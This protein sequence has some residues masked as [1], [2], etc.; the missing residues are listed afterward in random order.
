[1]LS[2]TVAFQTPSIRI[3]LLRTLAGVHDTSLL[4]GAL[5]LLSSLLN[6]Q[7]EERAWLDTLADKEQNEYL[8]LVVGSLTAQS[9]SLL[10]DRDSDAGKIIRSLLGH[11]Q[12]D[13]SARLRQLVLDR[14]ASGVLDSL[15]SEDKVA[16]LGH[17]VKTLHSLDD[18][19]Q[20]SV[21]KA[22][23]K[24]FNLDVTSLILV[25][26]DLSKPLSDSVAQP[27]KQ[28]QDGR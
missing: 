15:P 16:C 23:L 8:R 2:H 18:A 13:L 10:V 24:R 11:G 25:I 19:A 20:A 9:T 26:D 21:V 14:M 28:K 5:P 17:I 4:R 6:V 12:D 1:M 3:A 22:S 7:N 27:K